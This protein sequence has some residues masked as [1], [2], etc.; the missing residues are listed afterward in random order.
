VS[1][2][3]VTIDGEVVRK[4]YRRTHR[5]EPAREWAEGMHLLDLLGRPTA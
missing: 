1:D 2:H 5:G 4:R 3:D